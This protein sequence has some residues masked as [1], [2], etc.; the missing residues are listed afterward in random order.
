MTNN[1]EKIWVVT[2]EFAEASYWVDGYPPLKVGENPT[3]RSNIAGIA[4]K[5]ERNLAKV[6][7][8]GSS[9]TTRSNT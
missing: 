9:P 1:L 2:K 7:V 3:L 5:V 6:E 4:H 8:V